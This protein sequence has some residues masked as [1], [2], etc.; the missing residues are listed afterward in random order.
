MSGKL[1]VALQGVEERTVGPDLG[2]DSIRSG[3][4]ASIVA[5]V[6]VLMFMLWTYG[7]FGVYANIALALNILII[8][9][10]MSIFGATL[11][12]PGIAGFVLTIGAAVDANVLINE[13][14]REEQRRGRGIVQSVEPGDRM[15]ER[16][17]GKE[18]GSTGS[19]RGEA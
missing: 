12:L 9:G 17:V 15:A 8:M 19:L 3:I 16:R 18:W 10:V 2:A 14:I 1:P 7:R 6:A 11:T 4:I 5:T 13:R